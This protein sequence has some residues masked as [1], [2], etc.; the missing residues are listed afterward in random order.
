MKGKGSDLRL[1]LLSI[2]VILFSFILVG[3]LYLVQIVSSDTFKEKAEHQYVLGAN[4]FDRGSI[5]FTTKNDVLV[6]A[7][8]IK[9]GFILTI[10]PTI[11]SK[12][13]DLEDIYEKINSILPIERDIFFTKA[14]KS[15]D[16]YEELARRVPQ[17]TADAIRALKINGVS[18][19]REYWRF[20][21]GNSMAAHAIG[22]VG[23]KGD[24]YSGRYGLERHYEPILSRSGDKAF[25]NFFAEIFSNVKKGI[26]DESLEG[27]IVTTI[28]PS[29]QAFLEQE[30]QKVGEKYSSEFS[31]GII[32]DPKT[33]EI[34]AMALNPAFDPNFPQKEKD[35]SVF[36]NKFVEDRYEM[37]S[38]VK[39]L[40]MASAL[41]SGAV[42]ART[43]YDD[44][45]CMTLNS[46]TFCNYDGESHGSAVTMQTVLSK[47][48]NT[49]MAFA[50]NRM[51]NQAFADYMFRFGLGTTSGVDLPQEGNSLVSNLKTNRSLEYTQA[52]FGQGIALT[53]IIT[54]RALSVLANGG[55]LIT[56]HLV[57]ENRYKIGTSKK[58]EYPQGETVIKPETS[59]EI[60]RMLTESV[61]YV[62][63]EGS[64]RLE[65]HSVAAKT[66]TAQIAKSG[67]GGYYE[68]QFLHSFFGYF[69]SYDP[70]FLIF[71][72]TYNPRDVQYASE[73]LT[74]TFMN[75]TRF[76]INY[77]N[78]PPDREAA[79][80]K[81]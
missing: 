74:D 72:Y 5:F 39:A 57:K 59:E 36:R 10:N 51:G 7:A 78:I 44:P 19:Y 31:G 18:T 77:Y 35:S 80:P 27:D 53:P 58:Y 24:E 38:I 45:G 61:D 64:M 40:A 63:R 76:I 16:P 37:G 12:R 49:G 15:S 79:P 4:Y 73:T 32:I 21:P 47:S 20:Y 71:L 70:Q 23:Y 54:V 81:R 26:T 46:R 62:L 9:S 52:A 66:G 2:G 28:E 13:S 33:G 42:T 17:E 69:P 67:G 50:V 65:N 48:L 11:L 56:P 14:N 41:D 68:D 8:T 25:V 75:T 6:P 43:T 29:I 3:K 55:H 22:F 30:L 34:Y 1:R 60:S